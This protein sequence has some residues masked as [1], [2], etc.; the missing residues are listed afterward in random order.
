MKILEFRVY[1]GI[2]IY[3]HSPVIKLTVDLENLTGVT[4]DRH[5][6]LIE[7]VLRLMP[8]L[9]EHYCS[10]GR[11][12]GFVERMREGTFFGHLLE[13][14]I[15]ELQH[16][17]GFDVIYGKTRKAEAPGIYEVIFEYESREAGIQAARAAVNLIMTLL[18]GGSIDL[19]KELDIIKETALKFDL[20]PTTKA[21]AMEA[22]KRNIPVM[23]LGEGSILQLGYGCHQRRIEA[24]ITD[25]TGCIGVDIAGD[26]I[27]TKQI[28]SEAGI[29]VPNGGVA[30]TEKEALDIMKRINN[31][32]VI[33]PFNGNQGKGV[34][35]NL[36]SEGEVK[37]AYAVATNYSDRVIV[38]KFITGRHYRLVVVDD[39][40]VAA[41][42]RIPASVTGDGESTIEQLIEQANR[43]PLRGDGH[44]KPMTK[45]KIDP[46]VL[47]VLA[48]QNFVLQS[49]PPEGARVLLRENANLSTGGTAIDV[50]D[51]VH[52]ENAA[53]AVRAAKIIGLDVA[54]IDL[55][56]EDIAIPLTSCNGAVIEVNAAP[57]LRMHHYPSQGKPRNVARAI[58][59]K[60]F[61]PGTK[62]RIPIVA[63]TG[64]NGKTTTTR[65]I[66]H[67]LHAA[68]NVVG[69]TTSDGIYVN[70]KLIAKGDM[71]GP[72]SART[73]LRD[74]SVEV[75]VLETARGGIIRAGL[76]FDRC[77]VGI[78]TNISEDHLGIDG[79][80]TLE[81]LAF[82]K[83]VVAEATDRDGYVVLN[84]DDRL[85]SYVAS[86]CR[87]NIIYFSR[88][89]DN[90]TI[91][92]HLGAG[93][94]AV[95]VKNGFVV[96]ARG[97]HVVKIASVKSIPCTLSGQ[98]LHNVENVLAASAGCLGLGIPVAQ[99]KEGLLSFEPGLKGNP[100]R[101]NFFEVAGVKVLVD[102]G[103]NPAGYQSVLATA[104]KM[105]HKRLIGVIGVPGDRQDD[106]II[107]VGQIAGRGFDKIIIKE[108]ADPRG[109]K[110]GEV[111]NLLKKGVQAGGCS[112]KD[113]IIT[114]KEINAVLKAVEIA[115]RG[116]LVV[117]FYEKL[118]PVVNLLSA[119]GEFAKVKKIREKAVNA[120]RSRVTG[121]RAF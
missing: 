111:A 68:G 29:P 27:L 46:V 64:T 44:E 87:G 9:K 85:A 36:R 50:T 6:T 53:L 106:F 25:A 21:I 1:E 32:V 108:D 10:L 7:A 30:R 119:L 12:G 42:E 81:D 84:A 13:H 109:R 89:S 86:R 100:G 2:N 20:G 59:D 94:M 28:L 76:G 83:S 92:R 41:S 103:H 90:I 3:S 39:R 102:Y 77:D 14:V 105:K 38:E 49:I 96:Y 34:A 88:A 66:A 107:K 75:A 52:P 19:D 82:V 60:L 112:G 16:L 117:I 101:L 69:M 114:L 57:G 4:T 65:L 61:P 121:Q 67:I 24:S 97:N 73:V 31:A 71:T 40:V 72:V 113:V 33:K 120:V 74:N 116:D 54:G 45:I 23:R 62:S 70:G 58:V 91:R 47:M 11:P 18:Q 99:I 17:A 80:E 15:L 110:P 51:N 55:V 37:K 98:A 63:V 79:I 56:A 95:F 78:I 35:L 115:E 8:T 48:K 26:K 118:E 43:D 5:P 93:G 22:R 104:K